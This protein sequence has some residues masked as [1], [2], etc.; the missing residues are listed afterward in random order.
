MIKIPDTTLLSALGREIPSVDVIPIVCGEYGLMVTGEVLEEISRMPCERIDAARGLMIPP[1]QS[2]E[3]YRKI[4]SYLVSRYTVL[5]IGELSCIAT[6]LML[7]SEGRENYLVLDD[8][9]A[10]NLAEK[11]HNDD[12]IVR[13]LGNVPPL[14]FTGTFGLLIHLKSKGRI[15]KSECAKISDDLRHSTFRLNPGMLDRFIK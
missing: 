15:S 14:K 12:Q 1:L 9:P 3:R 7:S 5:H 13:I 11:I 8:K 2:G 10:R 4:V 6:S